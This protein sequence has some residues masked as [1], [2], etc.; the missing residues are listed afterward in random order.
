MTTDE[1]ELKERKQ[2]FTISTCNLH[3][4]VH[5]KFFPLSAVAFVERK[6]A[7]RRL[8]KALNLL[9]LNNIYNHFHERQKKN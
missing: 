1:A 4:N 2:V 8:E 7:D 5:A 9:L 6:T 3:S